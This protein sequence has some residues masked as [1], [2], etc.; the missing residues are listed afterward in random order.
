[1]TDGPR[2]I[3]ADANYASPAPSSESPGIPPAPSY[4]AR[5]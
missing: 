1:M 4:P 3:V 2:L 5:Q